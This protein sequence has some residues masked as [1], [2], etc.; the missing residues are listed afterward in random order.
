MKIPSS[1]SVNEIEINW[2]VE[3][4]HAKYGDDDRLTELANE[5]TK[6]IW[7][8]IGEQNHHKIRPNL[9]H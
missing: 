5:I 3:A 4:A 6:S 8:A 9:A 1:G 7:Q 2:R